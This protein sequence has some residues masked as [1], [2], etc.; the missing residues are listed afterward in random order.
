M[1]VKS[2]VAEHPEETTKKSPEM[3]VGDERTALPEEV[4]S[5]DKKQEEKVN[6]SPEETICE[7]VKKK[8]AQELLSGMEA[9]DGLVLH[10]FIDGK[11]NDYLDKVFANA[12]PANTDHLKAELWDLKDDVEAGIEDKFRRAIE[13]R[14][15]GNM[16]EWMYVH[17]QALSNDYKKCCLDMFDR[18]G[19]VLEEYGA[20]L[21]LSK[22]LDVEP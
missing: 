6:E 16:F 5:E 1:A 14:D 3:S 10:E 19:T 22:A 2:E 13:K 7:K 8:F 9:S 21:D 15:K 18:A 20:S 17:G 11:L 12:L 4:Q